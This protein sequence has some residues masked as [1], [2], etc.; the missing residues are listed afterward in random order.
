MN[1]S[2]AS[3]VLGDRS[4][5]HTYIRSGNVEFSA[6]DQYLAFGSKSNYSAA[7]QW[8]VS[9]NRSLAYTYTVGAWEIRPGNRYFPPS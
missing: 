1:Q 4:L 6:D 2:R 7:E 8:H 3:H 5:A 9:G